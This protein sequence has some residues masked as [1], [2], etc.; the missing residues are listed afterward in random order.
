MSRMVIRNVIMPI[1]E[2]ILFQ[3][4]RRV[5]IRDSTLEAFLE[6]E[7]RR[8]FGVIG[9]NECQHLQEQLEEAKRND[10]YA[11]EG[12]VRQLLERYAKLSMKL[13]NVKKL[14]K[15]R[16]KITLKP[17]QKSSKEKRV[18]QAQ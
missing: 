17:N 11:L 4:R 2:K 14:K 7:M 10:P 13:K 1:V 12:L 9:A 3:D 5:L 15:K 6:E 8:Y 18:A 16:A